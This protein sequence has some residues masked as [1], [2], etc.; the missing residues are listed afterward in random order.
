MFVYAQDK[1][2]IVNLDK[3]TFIYAAD[4]CNLRVLVG[5]S[6]KM[7]TLGRYQTS[8][9]AEIALEELAQSMGKSEIF[10]VP[11]SE[12]CLQV[13]R[14]RTQERP[15]KFATNGKKTVRRGGS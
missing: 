5:N 9:E 8:A 1:R 15:D 11:S 4:N 2:S 6:D 10:M 7:Y 12:H 13:M 3:A 14:H